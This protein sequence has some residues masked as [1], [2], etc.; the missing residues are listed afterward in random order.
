[1]VEDITDLTDLVK[2]AR[3]QLGTFSH[4][5]EAYL[6]SFSRAGEAMKEAQAFLSRPVNAAA[7]AATVIVALCLVNFLRGWRVV[8]RKKARTRSRKRSQK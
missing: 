1:M 7:V 5:R 3:G 6:P 4:G 8:V 2:S